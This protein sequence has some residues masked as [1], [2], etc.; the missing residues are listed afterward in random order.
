[1]AGLETELNFALALLGDGQNFFKDKQ[2][3]Y[4]KFE[5]VISKSIT[6][7]KRI[8]AVMENDKTRYNSWKAEAAKAK[9]PG[10]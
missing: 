7:R 4:K 8:R 5:R 1:M 9:K 10:S 6:A 2:D 3:Y